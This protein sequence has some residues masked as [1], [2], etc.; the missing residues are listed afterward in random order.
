MGDPSD[1]PRLAADAGPVKL[2]VS[3]GMR[4]SAGAPLRPVL[5]EV[6]AES[7]EVARRLEI[8]PGFL[9]GPDEPSECTVASWD[10]DLLLQ[11]LLTE[12][13]WIDPGTFR[14]VRRLS[15]PWM[16]GVHAA[17][18]RADGRLAVAS[19]GAD[20]VIHL[21]DDGCLVGAWRLGP[22]RDG[23]LRHLPY[24]ALKP[25]HAHPNGLAEVD[26]VL[27][28]TSLELRAALAEDGRVWPLG[29]GLPHDGVLREGRRWFSCTDGRIRALDPATGALVEQ[30]DLNALQPSRRRL[31]WCRGVEVTGNRLWAGL[32]MLRATTRR[33]VARWMFQGERGRK[34]PTRIVEVDRARRAIVRTIELG[35]DQGGTIYGV[36]NSRRP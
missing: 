3:M 21:D 14:V 8:E 23:D 34:L 30:I 19:A 11:P 28:V 4:A 10:G 25:H 9:A 33:E 20:A 5:V 22:V 16:H 29:D 31:G 32:S 27:W 26:G 35:N 17:V 6:D 1:R 24:G 2:L 13:V 15:H 12:L 18:R 36:L 7:G